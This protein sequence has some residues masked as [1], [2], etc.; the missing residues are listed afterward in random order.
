MYPRTCSRL[1]HN[2][3]KARVQLA[4]CGIVELSELTEMDLHNGSVHNHVYQPK[5]VEL[6]AMRRSRP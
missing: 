4:E 3:T 6:V 2:N 5:H 1:T